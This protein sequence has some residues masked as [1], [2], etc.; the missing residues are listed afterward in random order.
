MR[1]QNESHRL[2]GRVDWLQAGAS[3]LKLKALRLT[4]HADAL[5]T[6]IVELQV[7]STAFYSG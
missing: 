7:C 1:R 5:E 4:A 3:R 6:Q 2:T